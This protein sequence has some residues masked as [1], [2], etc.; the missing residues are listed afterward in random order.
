MMRIGKLAART[1]CLVETI[2]YYESVGVLPQ[3]QRGPNNYRYY[4]DAHVR[5]L[6]F[7]RRCRQLGFSLEEVRAFLNMIDGNHYRCA[8]VQEIGTAHLTEVRARL[9][10]LREMERS[11]AELLSRCSGGTTPDCAMLEVLFDDQSVP[12][13]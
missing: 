5:R 11:L 12:R 7:V 13:A 8:E 3:P 4:G 9:K 6:S 2:R 10:D 1:G